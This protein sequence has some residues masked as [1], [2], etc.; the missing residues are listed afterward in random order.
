HPYQLKLSMTETD[1]VVA[2]LALMGLDG[3]EAIYSR[4]TDEQR[5]DYSDMA[6]RH[7]LLATGGSDFHGSAKPD[8]SVVPGLVELGTAYELLAEV[9][10][11]AGRI[12]RNSRPAFVE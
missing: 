6:T 4:H 12:A 5:K 11:R 3:I 1:R 8:I 7:G 10:S 2:E 9:K